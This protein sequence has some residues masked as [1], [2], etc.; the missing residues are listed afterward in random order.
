MSTATT[1]KFVISRTFNAPLDRVWKAWTEPEQMAQWWGP[2]GFKADVKMLD[3]RPGGKFHYLLVSPQGQEMWGRMLFR[4]IVPK[5][6]LVFINSFSDPEG[7]VTRHPMAPDWPLL[8]HTTISFAE[9][10]EKTTVTIEWLPYEASDTE[11]ETFDEGR[12]SMQ[13]GWTGTFDKLEN[14]LA[15]A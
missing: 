15:D 10:D 3:L 5:E 14:H 11:C 4:E 7:G 2:K 1:Q 8:M 12:D 9:K 13:A 6:K